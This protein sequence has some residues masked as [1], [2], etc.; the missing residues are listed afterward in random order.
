MDKVILKKEDLKPGHVVKLRNGGKA[1]VMPTKSLTVLV[2]LDY[3]NNVR[4]WTDLNN[5]DTKFLHKRS[6]DFD[7][8]EIYGYSE[9]ATPSITTDTSFR[10]LLW[11]REEDKREMT[12]EQIEKAL[13]YGIKIIKEEK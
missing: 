8:V 11:K 13:G 1:L 5:F 9:F 7:I 12:I 2:F 6:K 3:K 10:E 4:A